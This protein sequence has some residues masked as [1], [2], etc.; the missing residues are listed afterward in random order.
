MPTVK[1]DIVSAF[2]A[3]FAQEAI[4]CPPRAL[5]FVIRADTDAPE[6]A[7]MV[8]AKPP[9]PDVPRELD[10]RTTDG[11]EVQLLWHPLDGHVSVAVNDSKTGEVFELEVR[12]GQRALDVYNHPYAYAAADGTETALQRSSAP[13]RAC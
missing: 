2:S 7:N 9:A 1:V 3:R 4:R 5:P 12:P 8:S 11:I 13:S 6:G 10:S